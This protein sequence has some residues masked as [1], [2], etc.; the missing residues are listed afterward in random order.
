MEKHENILFFRNNQIKVTMKRD[1][2]KEK[3]CLH[4]AMMKSS[5]EES[6]RFQDHRVKKG[7][8]VLGFSFSLYAMRF[9]SNH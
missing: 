8:G 1:Y 2:D 9:T 6:P 7:L 3:F 4:N 5:S